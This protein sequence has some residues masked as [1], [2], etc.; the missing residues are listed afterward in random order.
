MCVE[1][2]ELSRKT[3]YTNRDIV[4]FE[5]RREDLDQKL[6]FCGMDLGIWTCSN[7]PKDSSC[8]IDES[9]E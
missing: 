5:Y 9:E 1:I 2:L 6:N 4:Q 8:T 7:K 3:C